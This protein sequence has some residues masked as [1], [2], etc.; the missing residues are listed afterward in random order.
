VQAFPESRY[1]ML[2]LILIGLMLYRPQG[3]AARAR[4]SLVMA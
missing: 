3:I 1:A 4:P 2:G